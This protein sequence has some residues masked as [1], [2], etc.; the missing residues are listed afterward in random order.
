MG[1]PYRA[2]SVVD[3]GREILWD[4][5]KLY[6]NPEQSNFCLPVAPYLYPEPTVLFACS[7]ISNRSGLISLCIAVDTAFLGEEQDIID[8]RIRDKNRNVKNG[9]W[10]I[11]QLK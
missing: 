2:I 9:F 1:S 8:P 10:V 7:T 6:I 5:N 4:W 3:R 11:M